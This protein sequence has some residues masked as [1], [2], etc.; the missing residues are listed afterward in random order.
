MAAKDTKERGGALVLAG[1]TD[2]IRDILSV[3]G[4]NS[5]FDIVGSVEDAIAAK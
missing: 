2:N 5:L 1:L 3:S 4:F